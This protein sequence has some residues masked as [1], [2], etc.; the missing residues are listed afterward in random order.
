MVCALVGSLASFAVSTNHEAQE[1]CGLRAVLPIKPPGVKIPRQ[2][3]F[4]FPSLT[5]DFWPA[6][7]SVVIANVHFKSYINA[8]LTAHV[9]QLDSIP[10]SLKV[11]IV[12]TDS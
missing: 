9:S 2:Q 6:F 11:R 5:F 8:Q 3:C 10:C 1:D 4:P 12:M 7:S